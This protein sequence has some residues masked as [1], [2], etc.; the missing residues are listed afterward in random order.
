LEE[1]GAATPVSGARMLWAMPRPAS[2]VR[3]PRRP[4]RNDLA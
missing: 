3:K 1:V 4:G 2:G